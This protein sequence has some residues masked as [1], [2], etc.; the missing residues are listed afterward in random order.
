LILVLDTNVVVAGLLWAG[1]PRSLLNLAIDEAVALVSSPA[2]LDELARTLEYAKFAPRIERLGTTA[3]V[4][5]AQ[6]SAL[7]ILVSPAQV[8]RVIENDPDDD[9]V[10]A[11]AITAQANLI[12]SGDKHLLGLGGQY[13]GVSILTPAQ[14]F[15]Q[16]GG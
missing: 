4:L 3:P 6:Y 16:L 11:C 9:E 7:A 14:A 12:V 5:V 13:Q 8:P 10:L 15:L 2:L 1:P